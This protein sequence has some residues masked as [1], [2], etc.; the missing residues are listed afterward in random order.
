MCLQAVAW[1]PWRG[2]QLAVGGGIGA[3]QGL[4]DGSLSVWDV[5]RQTNL[6]HRLPTVPCAV[7]AIA[8]SAITAELIVSYW[9]EG[10]KSGNL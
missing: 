8:W 1:H 4:G 9:L 5:A 2:C 6:C 10:E 7:D 3:G